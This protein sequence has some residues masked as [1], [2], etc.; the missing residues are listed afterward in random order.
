MKQII[1]PVAAATA[2]CLGYAGTGYIKAMASAKTESVLPEIFY[3][4]AKTDFISIAVFEGA[5]VR[6][7]VSFR[8]AFTISDK[9]RI[10]E[11][12]YLASDI[13]VRENL[14]IPDIGSP[15]SELSKRLEKDIKKQIKGKLPDETVESLKVVDFGFDARV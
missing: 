14:S 9:A 2:V 12:G 1:L 3:E 11:V 5:K 15:H 6:G 7:Y 8:V 13:A 10:P 4:D